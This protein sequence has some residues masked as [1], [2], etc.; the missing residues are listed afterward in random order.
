M[1]LPDPPMATIGPRDA[2]LPWH[3]RQVTS[4]HAG[5]D[6]APAGA[7][8]ARP[9][10][11]YRRLVSDP[12]DE[13]ELSHRGPDG[14]FRMVDISAKATSERSAT[15]S[16]VVRCSAAALHAITN[17]DVGKGDVLA[18]ARLAGITAAKRTADLIPLCH[19]LVLDHVAVIVSEDAVMECINIQAT[20]R[21]IGRTGVEMEALTAV[22][23]AAL[24]VIDMAKSVDRFM[25]IDE[26]GL[27][28]KSGGR[29]GDI[30]RGPSPR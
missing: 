8:P 17:G 25:T 5:V 11:R 16:G 27:V 28:R 9:S 10:S 30:S 26:V 21:C 18:V 24:T 4:L 13:A 6:H 2:H 23:V 29:S 22:T 3:P 20:V 7:A 19:P 1:W 12:M 15:A 14:S